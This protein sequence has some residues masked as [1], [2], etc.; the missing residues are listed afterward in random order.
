MGT[1]G[2]R[3]SIARVLLQGYLPSLRKSSV[4]VAVDGSTNVAQAPYRILI[5]HTIRLRFDTT[6]SV[7]PKVQ[8]LNVKDAGEH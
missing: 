7:P 6:V 2:S 4:A 1:L 5:H 8:N 3:I